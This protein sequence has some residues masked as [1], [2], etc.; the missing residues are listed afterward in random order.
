[1][2]SGSLFGGQVPAV[3]YDP[4]SH[5]LPWARE[6]PTQESLPKALMLCRSRDPDPP[7]LWPNL[8]ST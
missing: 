8:T 5:Q 6:A 3:A 4:K 2:S 7:G 1:M